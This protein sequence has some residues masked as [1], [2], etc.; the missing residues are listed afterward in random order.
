MLLS[1]DIQMWS[2]VGLATVS[3]GLLSIGWPVFMTFGTEVSDR[4]K[5]TAVGLL[6]A[7]NQVSGVCGAGIGGVLLC[8]VR[9]PGIGYL[10]LRPLLFHQ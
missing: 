5:A 2:V 9:V 8:V 3:V 7:S 6:G 10:S 4:S 1:I